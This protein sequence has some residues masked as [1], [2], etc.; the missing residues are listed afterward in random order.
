MY[1]PDD[2]GSYQPDEFLLRQRAALMAYAKRLIETKGVTSVTPEDVVNAV[3][4]KLLEAPGHLPRQD[5]EHGMLRYVLRM[6]SNVVID[7]ARKEGRHGSDALD[8][9]A[10]EDVAML[11]ATTGCVTRADQV[12][13]IERWVERLPEKYRAILQLSMRYGLTP[14]EIGERLGIPARVVS[15]RLRRVLQRLREKL[16]DWRDD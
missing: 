14:E 9:D 5:G 12:R 4:V 2:E 7:A 1:R 16:R 3:F 15:R 11:V 13:W 8:V 6:V 10:V